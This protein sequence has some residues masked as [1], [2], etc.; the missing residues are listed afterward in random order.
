MTYFFY[1]VSTFLEFMFDCKAKSR[2]EEHSSIVVNVLKEICC[3]VL[4]A[5]K[6]LRLNHLERKAIIAIIFSVNVHWLQRN[7]LLSILPVHTASVLERAI[8][9]MI[10][11][12]RQE[13]HESMNEE[14]AKG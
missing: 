8:R 4:L 2:F 9:G 11:R 5:I 12:I 3:Y 10:E 7:L 6:R 13:E 1:L 14:N